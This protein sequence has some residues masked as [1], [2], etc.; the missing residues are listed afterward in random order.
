MKKSILVFLLLAIHLCSKAQEQFR[1]FK[2]WESIAFCSYNKYHPFHYINSDNNWE[3]LLAL[4]TPMTVTELANK[5]LKFNMSQLN[6]LRIGG[7]IEIK[8]KQLHTTLPIFDEEQTKKI[9]KLS[10]TI[11]EDGFIETETDYRKF[12]TILN[13]HNYKEN[14]FS[15]LFSYL[16]DGKTWSA[17]VPS[18]NEISHQFTW[19]GIA[20]V[21]F[22]PRKML[23]TGTN[24]FGTLHVTWSDSLS[25]FPKMDRIKLFQKEFSQYGKV[26]SPEI[27]EEFSDLGIVNKDGEITI[28]ILKN[29]EGNNINILSSTIV[30]KNVKVL[31]KGIEEFKRITGIIDDNY[32]KVILFHE[33]MW[34][35]IDLLKER[36]LISMPF[37]LQSSEASK[38][39]FR[40][41]AFLE[42]E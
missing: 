39:D 16:L 30:D 8:G 10:R 33:M 3:L 31:K 17:L 38:Q 35:T 9:R 29:D 7:L 28:P 19:D 34:D 23:K 6:Y 5:G 12:V 11:A 13:E 1:P 25:V 21:M 22:E 20:Y 32:A 4:R 2:E 27:R 14:A 36:Q 42:V 15:I 41:I 24:I 37:I 18:K 40:K 26:I